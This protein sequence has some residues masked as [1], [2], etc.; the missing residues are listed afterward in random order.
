M[1]ERRKM[2]LRAR[3]RRLGGMRRRKEGEREQDE[4]AVCLKEGVSSRRVEGMRR[5]EDKMDEEEEEEEEEDTHRVEEEECVKEGVCVE[6]GEPSD[7]GR[8]SESV[9]PD[10]LPHPVTA[11]RDTHSK[12][13]VQTTT[14]GGVG[15]AWAGGFVPRSSL[16]LTRNCSNIDRHL[17]EEIVAT[18]TR[19]L[20]E[21]ENWVELGTPYT[22]THTD[23]P[24]H[25]HTLTTHTH[26]THTYT[27][28]S[29][30]SG[31]DNGRSGD[32]GK[33]GVEEMET[34]TSLSVRQWNRG[35]NG[36]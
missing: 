17:C 27:G 33:E 20:L 1:D 36:I 6:G 26:T 2:F 14:K 24:I 7:G 32:R 13:R 29:S 10:C 25:T 18:I 9:R 16:E 11:D 8:V 15:T 34:A 30:S 31:S 22:H 12:S 35:G 23:I 21:T 28:Q 4:E 5:K 19:V 3:C